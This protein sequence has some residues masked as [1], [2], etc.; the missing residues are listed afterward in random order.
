MLCWTLKRPPTPRMLST[1]TE[2]LLFEDAYICYLG[3]IVFSMWLLAYI[4]I[5]TSWPLVGSAL[6]IFFRKKLRNVLPAA[7]L[8]TTVK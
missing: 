8:R 5:M 7:F 4:A 3:R 1:M 6:Q 2:F